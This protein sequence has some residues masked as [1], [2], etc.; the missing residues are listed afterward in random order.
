M[1]SN[2]VRKTILNYWIMLLAMAILIAFGIYSAQAMADAGPVIA[3][4]N[5]AAVVD[6]ADA[7]VA[8]ADAGTVAATVDPGEDPVGFFKS[9]YDSAKSGQW[10]MLVSLIVIALVW[11]ARKW[12]AKKIDW[13]ETDR[14]G[15]VLALS[16]GILGGMAHGILAEGAPTLQMLTEAVKVTVG[17][18]G[19]YVAIKK[20]L[21][22]S[23]KKV[24]E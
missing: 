8:A 9:T 3:D 18:M 6:V 17:A 13:F 4:T 10:W 12:G 14:G 7:G 16:V 15:A 5:V 19:G 1:N 20:S 22:P 24:A 2:L 23:D 11:V 21:F